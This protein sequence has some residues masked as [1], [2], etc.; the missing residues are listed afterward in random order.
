[1][2]ISGHNANRYHLGAAR[3]AFGVPSRMDA[4]RANIRDRDNP[5]ENHRWMW[6]WAA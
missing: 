6:R 3:S 5:A 4:H 2:V 1:M